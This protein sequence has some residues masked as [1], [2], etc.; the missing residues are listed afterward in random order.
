[1][2]LIYQSDI[3]A[4]IV[5]KTHNLTLSL[6]TFTMRVEKPSGT[7]V[8]WDVVPDFAIGYFTHTTDAGD[9]DEE[10]EYKAQIKATIGTDVQVSDISTFYVY[11]KI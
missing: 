11:K 8:V 7:I 1:M 3:G 2:S 5:A 9:I 4:K 6:G 10:G